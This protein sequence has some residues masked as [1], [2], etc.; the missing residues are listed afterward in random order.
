[1][2]WIL[3]LNGICLLV[4]QVIARV[5]AEYYSKSQKNHALLNRVT[6]ATTPNEQAALEEISKKMKITAT[7][8]PVRSVGVQGMIGLH[9]QIFQNR[10]YFPYFSFS[11]WSGDSRSYSYVLGLST[12]EEPD[13]KDLLFLAKLIPR[14]LHNINR[15]CYVFGGAVQFP[16]NDIT[17][18]RISQ[19][20]LAQLRQAD[21]LANTVRF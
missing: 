8:L 14:I 9:A 15:V 16:I 11:I 1:M 7:L 4:K 12:D 21:H 19:Y 5:I 10:C 18:T 13:W 3:S 2:S 20:T 6:N 17:E